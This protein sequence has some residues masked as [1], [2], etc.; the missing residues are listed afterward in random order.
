MTDYKYIDIFDYESI[1]VS[2]DLAKTKAEHR[3]ARKRKRK[4]RT[5]NYVESLEKQ[6]VDR[7]A[8]MGVKNL[9]NDY[10]HFINKQK[11]LKNDKEKK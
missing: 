6:L 7:M 5:N 11:E 4:K 10:R 2:K 3:E 8:Y 1:K 9:N